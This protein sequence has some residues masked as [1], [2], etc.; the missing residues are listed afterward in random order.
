MAY[1]P[2]TIRERELNNLSEHYLRIGSAMR[3]DKQPKE[4]YGIIIDGD[5]RIAAVPYGHEPLSPGNLLAF[6]AAAKLDVHDREVSIHNAAVASALGGLMLQ[7]IYRDAKNSNH[8]FREAELE[9][10][11]DDARG[12]HTGIGD[13]VHGLPTDEISGARH[14]A[15]RM[16]R[17]SRLLYE[18]RSR[19]NFSVING[20]I[21]RF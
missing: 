2:R 7:G 12:L 13:V 5:G 11:S 9:I 6:L 8:I 19:P 15:A 14:I 16:E 17:I 4:T 18:L 3:A 10:L 1:R 21:V 20:L